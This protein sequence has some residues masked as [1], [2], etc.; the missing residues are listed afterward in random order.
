MRRVAGVTCMVAG[1]LFTLAGSAAAGESFLVLKPG[2]TQEIVGLSAT[3]IGGVA[4][5]PNGDPWV[6]DCGGGQ[7][8][9]F[10]LQRIAPPIH[11]TQL[12]PVTIVNSAVDCGLANHPDGFIY[13][14]TLDGVVQVNANTG[15]PTGKVVGPPGNR[16]GIA[17]DPQTGD[18][19]YVTGPD[20]FP[21]FPGPCGIET[22]DPVT[23]V[24]SVFVALPG[25]T[26]IDGIAFEPGGSRLF[27][28]NFSARS[29]IVIDRSAPGARNGTVNREIPISATPDGI[30][31]HRDGFLVTSNGGGTLTKIVLGPPDVLSTF[32]SGGGRNDLSQ[33]GPDGCLY[34]TQDSFTRFD[35]GTVTS[36]SS[37]VRICPGFIP[38]TCFRIDHD[39]T[40]ES[41]EECVD[42]D[43][44]NRHREGE[45]RD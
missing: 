18:L 40:I 16:F 9:R 6:D 25:V 12:H 32:A 44:R 42:P 10:D 17:T 45:E 20:C 26:F 28:S 2:F 5:A 41:D 35:D 14:N 33:V 3:F 8:M 36:D 4:F 43:R 39:D 1:A 15:L 29:V 27:L 23:G 19:V 21:G 38:A 13:S 34:T 37:L 24:A 30:A 22:V 31:F 7:L 11:G